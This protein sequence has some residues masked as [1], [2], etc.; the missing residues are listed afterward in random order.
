MRSRLLA[1]LLAGMSV[2]SLTAHAQETVGG[3]IVALTH[4]QVNVNNTWQDKISVLVANCATPGQLTEVFYSP[5]RLSDRAALGHL[6]EED[7]NAARAVVM[8]GA[9]PQ[10]QINGYG[11][12]WVDDNNNVRRTGILGHDV[13]C[14]TIPTL[15]QQF[16]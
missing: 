5:G 8:N 16:P 2:L 11:L 15:V 14:G 1:A 3:K 13:D 12:F 10:R 7:V 6:F 9:P 4:Q